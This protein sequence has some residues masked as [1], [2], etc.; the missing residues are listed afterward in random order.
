MASLADC[1]P[2]RPADRFAVGKSLATHLAAAA[3]IAIERISYP[4][5]VWL[6]YRQTMRLLDF[7]DRTL[8]DFGV[9]R[10]DVHS[11]LASGTMA[12]VALVERAEERRRAA[13][14]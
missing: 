4:L 11:S 1:T 8:A 12:S 14:R 9:T 3:G 2:I 5:R 13:S 6:D 7:D 10:G